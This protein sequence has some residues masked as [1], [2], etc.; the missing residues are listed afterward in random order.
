MLESDVCTR[1]A[2]ADGYFW[3]GGVLWVITCGG[4]MPYDY[5]VSWW[6]PLAWK[7]QPIRE[8]IAAPTRSHAAAESIMLVLCANLLVLGAVVW[9][10]ALSAWRGL[11]RSC[12]RPRTA[13]S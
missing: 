9:V 5:A 12:S 7:D 8:S 1:A 13:R 4:E 3:H 11:R 10:L 6:W 2:G